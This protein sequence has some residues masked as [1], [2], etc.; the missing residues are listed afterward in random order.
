MWK[1]DEV[2]TSITLAGRTLSDR[3]YPVLFVTSEGVGR[4]VDFVVPLALLPAMVTG[5]RLKLPGTVSSQLL[6]NVPNIQDVFRLWEQE[7]RFVPQR[8]LVD[9]KAR[10]EGGERASGVACFFSGGVDSFYTLLKNHDEVTHLI[11]VHGFDIPLANYVLREQAS[12]AAREVAKE[13]GKSLIEVATNVRT[14]SDPLVHWGQY[15]G[16]ALASVGLLFQHL[17][18]KIL[19]P[20]TFSYAE[21][22]P[23]GTHPLLDPL[24]STELT[25]FEHDGCEATRPKKV[26]YI[27]EHES[28]MKW[29]RVCWL[30][31]ETNN[32][33]NC[34]RCGKCLMTM[35]SL[36]AAGSLGRCKTLPSYLDPQDIPNIDRYDKDGVILARQHIKA[37]ERTGTDPNLA[38]AFTRAI[39]PPPLYP[40]R[41]Y[42]IGNVLINRTPN[43][44]G[45]ERFVRRGESA[46]RLREVSEPEE[47]DAAVQALGGSITQSW[48]WGLFYQYAVGW[49][50]L[51]LLDEGGRGAV[52]LLL[53]DHL[54]GF[55]EAY[56]PYGPLAVHASDLS[57][58]AVSAAS[59]AR[60]CRA[61]SFKMEP[62]W[63]I[64][65][66]N[67]EAFEAGRYVQA[68]RELPGSTLIID[69]PGDPEEHLKALPEDV[70]SGLMR[71]RQHGVEIEIV[72]RNSLDRGGTEDF[73][74]LLEDTSKRQ[75]FFFAPR[76][77]YWGLM[78]NL[79]VHLLVARRRG[80]PVA[81]ALIAT[82]GEEAY[83]FYGAF[84][85]EE[86]NLRALDLVQWE[87]MDLARQMG[88]SRYDMWGMP[89]RPY[90]GYWA[91]GFD[92][93]KT[94]YGGTP[95]EYV[96]ACTQVLSRVELWEHRAIRLGI[97]GYNVL[98]KTR[99][100]EPIKNLRRRLVN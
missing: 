62:R 21:L 57:K 35:A 63:G 29:L 97:G 88:C 65:L 7:F 55:I 90:P 17:F 24:W 50:P 69:I 71:S 19:I 10:K 16:A 59:R 4:K 98:K 81:G 83:Y 75:G 30:N 14:F 8:V 78:M 48:E 18:R 99:A 1:A 95:V 34:G 3:A 28:A 77:F 45:M 82:F 39:K 33:Y 9:S 22:L 86:E 20:A 58:I 23:W 52:Q 66:R 96:G 76:A 89:Y 40:S 60:E 11:F 51:R 67:Q 5:S 37:L 53:K 25:D 100:G 27:S 15:Q 38:Q 64:E 41:T 54:G 72:S 42:R 56:A 49:K 79:P 2:S 32:T 94:R 36:R 73:L 6:S 70:R 85:A 87:A 12:H 80:E 46:I 26:A 91:W 68:N 47:W 74:D 13:M 93:S 31:P 43:M 92:P 44:P 61:Y 84:T